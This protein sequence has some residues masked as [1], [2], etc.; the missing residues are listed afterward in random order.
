[1]IFVK[2]QNPSQPN[3]LSER[4]IAFVL[5]SA[6]ALAWAF[7]QLSLITAVMLMGIATLLLVQLEIKRR[8]EELENRRKTAKKKRQDRRKGIRSLRA[9]ALNS[10]PSPI[11]LVNE[12]RLISFANEQATTLFGADIV[13][14]DVFL[15]L[16][17]TNFVAA[18]DN[19]LDAKTGSNDTIRFTTSQDRAFDITITAI[20]GKS[21]DGSRRIQAMVY[22][23]EVTRL[24]QTEQMR[25]DF[26]ANASHELRTPL[27]T[28]SGFIETLQGPAAD[29]L[30]AQGRFLGIMQ[31]EAERMQRLIDDLLSLSRIEMLRHDMP[32]DII[33][34]PI[35][36][37]QVINTCQQDAQKRGVIFELALEEIATPIIGDSDQLTQVLLNLISNAAK[38]ADQDTTV[39][40]STATDMKNPELLVVTIKD[41]GPGI[42][43]EHLARLT[44][45]FYRVDTARS[46]KM[47]GTG[48]GLAIVKH[49][50]LR[51][52]SA[53]DI[54]SEV[55]VG[56]SFSFKLP[57]SRV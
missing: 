2:K 8:R 21:F 11:L 55:G 25:V 9:T 22:F 50:L 53:L 31:H 20:S 13:N 43:A 57:I 19:V 56:T 36:I 26:V 17:Q 48:L 23:Y 6:I 18:L 1:V 45:R 42:A 10:L 44:E 52:D 54:K 12:K 27:T 28:I 37:E 29:D 39:V 15:Y 5:A 16:R 35:L 4:T 33:D 51:H 46:R 38:Y 7:N 3:L 47:G 30:K 32:D 40:I 34:L 24:L 14:N 49:I 41:Q